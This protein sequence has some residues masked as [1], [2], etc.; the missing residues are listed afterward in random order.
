M[1][2]ALDH[3]SLSKLREAKII[4]QEEVAYCVGDKYVAENVVSKVRRIIDVPRSM[5]ESKQ[6]RRILKG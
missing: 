5:L 3:E 4:T 2:E 1:S 6:P